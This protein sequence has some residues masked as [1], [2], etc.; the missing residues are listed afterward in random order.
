MPLSDLNRK[1]YFL[2]KEL[3]DID[4]EILFGSDRKSLPEL[5]QEEAELLEQ[6]EALYLLQLDIIQTGYPHLSL[7]TKAVR[8]QNI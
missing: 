1:I 8:P 7:I 5:E 2:L 3:E 6:L 4:D